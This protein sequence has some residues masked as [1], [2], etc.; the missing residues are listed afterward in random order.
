V[1]VRS[2]LPRRAK[3]REAMARAGEGVERMD[4]AEG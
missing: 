1:A 2:E 4:G 3:A